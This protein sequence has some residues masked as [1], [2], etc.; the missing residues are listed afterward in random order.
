MLNKIHKC[1]RLLSSQNSWNLTGVIHLFGE[2]ADFVGNTVG[3]IVLP[4]AG[5]FW[6]WY[7]HKTTIAIYSWNCIQQTNNSKLIYLL[8]NMKN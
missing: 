6:S 7:K 3:G 1:F 2:A 5:D 8:K 4:V